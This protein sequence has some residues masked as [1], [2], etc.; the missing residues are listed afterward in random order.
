MSSIINNVNA[1]LDDTGEQEKRENGWCKECDSLVGRC[2]S[3]TVVAIAAG[4]RVRIQLNGVRIEYLL[5][6]TIFDASNETVDT[7]V[8]VVVREDEQRAVYTFHGGQRAHECLEVRESIVH[9]YNDD[10]VGR[11]ER[12]VASREFVVVQHGLEGVLVADDSFHHFDGRLVEFNGLLFGCL[13]G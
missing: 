12:A 1:C 7:L 3:R 13:V 5:N 11:R 8:V 2:I 6:A 9:L 4:K 10:E